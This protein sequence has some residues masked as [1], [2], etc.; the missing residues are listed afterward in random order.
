LTP[1]RA[2]AVTLDG[3]DL[4]VGGMGY[5]ALVDLEQ[6]KI[7]KFARVPSYVNQI[8]IGGGYLWAFYDWHL[9]RALLQNIH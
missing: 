6:E 2:T 4:W 5:V 1:G 8:Q 7:R 3:N 9:H